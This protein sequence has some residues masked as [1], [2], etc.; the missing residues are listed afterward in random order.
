[1][2]E[3]LSAKPLIQATALELALG[4]EVLRR[5]LQDTDH[6]FGFGQEVPCD[7]GHVGGRW[8]PGNAEDRAADSGEAAG[9][10]SELHARWAI[11]TMNQ[12]L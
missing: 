10:L 4:F 6:R 8:I 12:R 11:V 3:A 5:R 9:D 7:D 1:M 2:I